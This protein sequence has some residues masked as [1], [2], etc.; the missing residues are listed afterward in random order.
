MTIQE[1]TDIVHQKIYDFLLYVY[2]LLRKYPKYE[3]FSLQT[4]TR[5]EILKMLEEITAWDKTGTK[6]HLYAVD[7]ALQQSK[8]LLRLAND[9]KYSAMNA[10]HYGETGRK[11]KEIGVMLHD[12]IEEVKAAK[13]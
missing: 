11:L 10:Q 8:E 9:L 13:K 4:V 3:K 5:N 1:K 12:L 6:S 7:T 2:P